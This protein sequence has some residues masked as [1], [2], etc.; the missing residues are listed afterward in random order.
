VFPGVHFDLNMLVVLGLLLRTKSVT[1][2]AQ[3]L[4]VSQPSV[5]RS[6]SQLRTLLDD[7]LLV[8]T[9]GGM[10]LTRRAEELAA[11][12]QNWLAN[13]SQLLEPPHFDAATLE[14]R[15]RV[16]TTDFGVAAVV[17]PSLQ[18]I[19]SAAPGVALDIQPFSADMMARLSSGELDLII[20]GLDPDRSVTYD[21]YLFT[22]DF[23]CLV[24]RDHPLASGANGKPLPLDDFLAWPHISFVVSDSEYDRV[25]AKLG[26]YAAQRRVI[27][28]LPY[29]QAAPHLILGS[30]AIMTLPSRAARSFSQSHDLAC[31]PAPDCFGTIGYRLLWN[32]RSR[33]DPAV[34]WLCD[35][36]A[37][38]CATDED[39][40]PLHSDAA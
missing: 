31:L 21:R 12:L 16:A 34:Q 33:R 14:R 29:F 11:P 5:S 1:R 17:A 30:Q 37:A 26:E 35:I 40:Q 24:N 9:A 10:E 20:S 32:E 18:A 8:R 15:F 23:S 2:T 27:A 6:L 22:E 7:P 3:Q 38:H 36:F 13:T 4:G 19:A 28:R 25:D 39:D